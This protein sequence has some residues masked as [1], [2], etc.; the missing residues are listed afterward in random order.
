MSARF[1]R[2]IALF[3]TEGQDRLGHATVVVLGVGGLGMHLI[4]QFAY[5][6]V[7]HLAFADGETVAD[8]N[9]N[10]LIG[11]YPGDVGAYKVEIAKRLVSAVRPDGEV[12]VLPYDLP[13]ARVT[14]SLADAS[15]VVG[16]FDQELPRLTATDLCSAAG[17]PYVDVATE[18][19]PRPTGLV[20]GGRVVVAD[21]QGCLSCLEIL[22]MEELARE[23]MTDAQRR[24]HDKIYGL[25]RREL[26]GS[27][28]SV[29]TLNG[30]V[31]SLAAM[32]VM[33]L[34]TGLRTSARQLHYRGDLS[35][36][37]RNNCAGRDDCPYC[38]RWHAA[39]D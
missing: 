7:G 8:T 12:T 39:S 3:G 10:R 16:C 11:A 15:V 30:V 14:S 24:D 33:C 23:R 9:L 13:D 37:T 28:P 21:G 20:Y 29:V 2:Q 22:D 5:L 18:V 6:G 31:A 1:D 26:D 25:D 38:R 35:T 19:F 4:Q 32:E 27:G 17:V 34:L 36:V